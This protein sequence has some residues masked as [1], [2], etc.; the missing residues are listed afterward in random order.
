MKYLIKKIS[1][2]V[3]LMKF[4]NIHFLVFYKKWYCLSI[5]LSF[6]LFIKENHSQPIKKPTWQIDYEESYIYFEIPS[7]LNSLRG[8]IKKFYLVNFKFYGNYYSLTN[9]EL[10]IPVK[11]ITT[12][13]FYRDQ[14]LRSE[15]NLNEKDF[16][17][18]KIKILKI[19][20]FN[21]QENY[22]F[23]DFWVEIKNH[24]KVYKD[25]AFI[26]FQ[27]NQILANGETILSLKDFQLNGNLILNF[28]FSDNIKIK[29]KI[30]IKRK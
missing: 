11:S 26:Q 2:L 29:Y 19:Y 4:E 22:Y 13:N 28:V 10:W 9:N 1:L 3:S 30:V 24:R 7:I 23:I 20:P 5:V 25:I 15:Y 21:I 17:Y 12:N 8:E 6:F 27:W 14:N 16:P 18:I